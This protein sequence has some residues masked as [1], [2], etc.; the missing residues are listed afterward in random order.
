MIHKSVSTVFTVQSTVSTTMIYKI[1]KGIWGSLLD[2]R[3]SKVHK[4]VSTVFTVESTVSTTLI[5]KI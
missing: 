4:S 5:Y 2:R 1:Q 3:L